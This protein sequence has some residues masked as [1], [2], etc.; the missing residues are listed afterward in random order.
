MSGSTEL[1]RSIVA[2]LIGIGIA[3][4]VFGAG[5]LAW[6]A[7]P[8]PTPEAET[9]WK[10]VER[11]YG[12]VNADLTEREP[13]LA[14]NALLLDKTG[15]SPPAPERLEAAMHRSTATRHEADHGLSL[16]GY[17]SSGTTSVEPSEPTDGYI[18]VSWDVLKGG[19]LESRHE[20]EQARLRAKYSDIRA[21]I[22]KE[23]RELR[24]LRGRVHQ[25]FLSSRL[26]WLT[27]KYDL[28]REAYRV[29]R[30]GYFQGW[31]NL[32]ELMV[33]ESDLV[34]LQMD[35]E[36]SH[37][38]VGLGHPALT[39]RPLTPPIIDIDL[40]AVL[41]A[42]QNDHR[43]SHLQTAQQALASEN[44][45]EYQ[46]RL[47]LFVRQGL[48]PNLRPD[49]SIGARFSMPLAMGA[50]A[51]GE[52]LRQEHEAI[53]E[54]IKL[55]R[56]ER[57]TSARSA[58]LDFQEQ[59]GK[60]TQQH[61]RVSRAWER[62][63]R[64]VASQSLGSQ[65]ENLPLAVTRA[66]AL[67]DAK[68]EMIAAQ[69]ALYRRLFE[70]FQAANLPVQLSALQSIQLPAAT[71]RRR[72]GSRLT[73]IWSE[74]LNRLSNEVLVD[75]LVAKGID[76]AAVSG[77]VG[78]DTAKLHDLSQLAEFRGIK[79]AVLRGSPRWALSSEHDRVLPLLR[80]AADLTGRIH[81]DIEPHLLPE[82]DTDAQRV[83]SG[84]IRLLRR[85]RDVTGPNTHISVSVPTHWPKATYKDLSPLVDEVIIMAY[86]MT[87]SERLAER[88]TRALTTVPSYKTRI[89]LRPSDFRDEWQ[90]EQFIEAIA[91]STGLARFA[92]HD[93]NGYMD[94]GTFAE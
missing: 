39:Q 57:A 65:E 93:L 51:R 85:Y 56:W 50:E 79:I 28:M 73:Y 6:A 84:Y 86:G 27:F 74:S 16:S 15:C 71:D 52:A 23:Q 61:Y 59:L 7:A 37:K 70:V 68:L 78:S 17:A 26:R 25:A 76:H 29:E 89:A 83:L 58:H 88:I 40:G 77:G 10:Q 31:A 33:S 81:L 92:I 20:A 48:D 82:Y 63:R 94:L 45:T 55:Q 72:L 80:Q 8:S 87:D 35:L 69:E 54:R 1:S 21:D 32:D 64:S 4:L 22:N 30:R 9:L 60:T 53:G 24:C 90:L 49:V 19:L 2:L 46:N 13:P 75:F 47:R 18:E 44:D 34:R 5:N 42:I 66:R 14:S 36:V 67:A 41:T 11:I 3:S 91:E 62:L 12:A 43:L 38:T